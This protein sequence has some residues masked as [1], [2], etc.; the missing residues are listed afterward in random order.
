M[1]DLKCAIFWNEVERWFSCVYH[2]SYVGQALS[3]LFPLK[4]E[5]DR[6]TFLTAEAQTLADSVI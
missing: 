4:N 6:T 5:F 1:D 3:S 2:T